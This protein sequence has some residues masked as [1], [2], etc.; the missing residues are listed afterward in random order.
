MK[1]KVEASNMRREIY[2]R[3]EALQQIEQTKGHGYK[4]SPDCRTDEVDTIQPADE[5]RMEIQLSETERNKQHHQQQQRQQTL[6]IS[7]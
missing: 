6:Y 7:V 3:I 4:T 1:M 5:E 2:V